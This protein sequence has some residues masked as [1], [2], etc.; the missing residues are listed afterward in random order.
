[1]AGHLAEL[2]SLA[3]PTDPGVQRARATI[4]SARAARAT[5]TMAKGVFNWAARESSAAAGDGA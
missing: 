5:S 3:A 2:A 4:F 1:V